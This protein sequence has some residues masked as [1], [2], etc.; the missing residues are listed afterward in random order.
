M[1]ALSLLAI[2][3]TVCLLKSHGVSRVLQSIRHKQTRGLFF[4]HE[5]Q[6]FDPT[7]FLVYFSYF[8]SVKPIMW[9]R[10]IPLDWFQLLYVCYIALICSRFLKLINFHA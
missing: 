3:P 2:L 4:I 1:N 9:K 10:R 8:Y 7:S 5:L 6:V